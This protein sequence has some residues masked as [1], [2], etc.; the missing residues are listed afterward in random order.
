ML[1]H[2]RTIANQ[3]ARTLTMNCAQ[4][5]FGLLTSIVIA[6]ALGPAERGAYVLFVLIGTTVAMLCNPAIY[7]SANYYLSVNRWSSREALGTVSLVSLGFGI[8]AGAISIAAVLITGTAPALASDAVLLVSLG[9]Y[10]TVLVV[11]NSLSGLFFG[12]RKIS[13]FTSWKIC[14]SI[15][16]CLIFV[17]LPFRSADAKL[18]SIIFTM[19][20]ICDSIVL[21]ILFCSREGLSLVINWRLIREMLAYGLPVYSSRALLFVSQRLD[22]YMIFV[23]AGTVAL[24]QYTIAVTLAEQIWILPLSISQIMMPNIGRLALREAAHTTATV[25]RYASI[26]IVLGALAFLLVIPW[27]LPFLYGPDYAAAIL[28]FLLLLPGTAAIGLYGIVE[29]FFQS[30]GRPRLPL[31]ITFIGVVINLTLNVFLIPVYGMAGAALASSVAYGVQLIIM[32]YVFVRL[33]D[34]PLNVLLKKGLA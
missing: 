6:R 29:P 19:L 33:A 28:P 16:Q 2:L 12:A 15:L 34:L 21:Y 30:R 18:Y 9:I 32:Y 11:S 7:A 25:V 14:F 23:L 20:F 10:T 17:V 3:S 8:L 31:I 24:G 4:A 13:I 26:L 5:V 22:T 1:T 27:L